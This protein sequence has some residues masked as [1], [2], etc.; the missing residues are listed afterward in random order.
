MLYPSIVALVALVFTVALVGQYRARRKAHQLLWAI[1]L[2]LGFL[3]AAGYLAAL[4]GS[5]AGFR[6]Y[7][8]AGALWMAPV[9]G[10]GSVYLHYGPDRSRWVAALVV[11]TGVVASVGVMG[12]PLDGEALARL[13]GGPGQD[14]LDLAGLPLAALILSNTFGVVAV[15]ALAIR[16]ALRSR[17]TPDGKGFTVGNLLLA[18]GVI[19]LGMAGS[20][21]RLGVPGT[22]WIM[23]ALGFLILYGG[24]A[25]INRAAARAREAQP[26]GQAGARV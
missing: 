16:S 5:A 3:G 8:L 18:L 24:F 25:T 17:Y 26:G 11:L 22:F 10:L 15:A 9:M 4:R 12:A 23:M 14:V 21:A 2:A 7:Y 19:L 20:L 13:D 6:L 1:A